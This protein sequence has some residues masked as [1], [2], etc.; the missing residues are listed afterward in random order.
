M[1]ALLSSALLV[2]ASLGGCTFSDED[3]GRPG[4]SSSSSPLPAADGTDLGACTDAECEVEVRENDRLSL[5]A[6][7]RVAAMSVEYLSEEKITLKLDRVS[8]SLE[9][10][11][12]SEPDPSNF[13][14]VY[15]S[16]TAGRQGRVNDIELR[17]IG[18]DSKRA[19]L[20]LKPV[21]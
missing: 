4:G 3:G 9:L 11:G 12:D 1:R 14:A 7:W 16:V 6:R 18:G 19:I 17:M 5:D 20:V 21:T 15:L 10:E 8:G 13:D 2:A